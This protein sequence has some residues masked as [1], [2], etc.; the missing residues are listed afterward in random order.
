MKAPT[1][2][3]NDF[4]LGVILRIR[5]GSGSYHGREIPPP[6][7]L[8]VWIY[9]CLALVPHVHQLVSYVW[10]SVKRSLDLCSESVR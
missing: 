5:L 6:G 9:V 3:P 10:F 1:P 4:H 7:L 8:D 2:H